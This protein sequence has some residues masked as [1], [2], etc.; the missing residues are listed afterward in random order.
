MPQLNEHEAPAIEKGGEGDHSPSKSEQ[1]AKKLVERL[2]S[3]AKKHRSKYDN[4]WLDYYKFFRGKQWGSNR[5]SYRHSE[6]INF[7]FQAIQ[8]SV[9]ILTD[10]QPKIEFLPQEPSDRDLAEIFNLLTGS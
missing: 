10:R 5:P 4:K 9:P 8:S 1:D 7:V 3:K 2:F 6:V